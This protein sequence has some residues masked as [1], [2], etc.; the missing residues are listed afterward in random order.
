LPNLSIFRSIQLVIFFVCKQSV[1]TVLLFVIVK[2][3]IC[4]F[5]HD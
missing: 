1:I 4:V 5:E 3:M 2:A